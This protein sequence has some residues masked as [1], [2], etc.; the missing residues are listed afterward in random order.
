MNLEVAFITKAKSI[1]I[2][3]PTEINTKIKSNEKTKLIIF[4]RFNAKIIEDA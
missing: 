2:L 4:I 1:I 3:P